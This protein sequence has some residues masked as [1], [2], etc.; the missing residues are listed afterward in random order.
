MGNDNEV[1]IE[2]IQNSIVYT[3]KPNEH[4]SKLYYLVV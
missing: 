1:E 3:K 2:A 4:P